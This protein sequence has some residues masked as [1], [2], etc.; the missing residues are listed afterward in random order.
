MRSRLARWLQTR[1]WRRLPRLLKLPRWWPWVLLAVLLP[2]CLVNLAVA[3]VGRCSVFPLSPF[4]LRYKVEALGSYAWHR[5]RC[6]V[7]PDTPLTA[8]AARARRARTS[9][10][11]RPAGGDRARRIGR[12]AAPHLGGRRDGADAA[13]SAH[14]ARHGSERSLQ[15][16]RERGR[17]GPLPARAARHLSPRAPGC[18]R[19]QRRPGRDCRSAM[20]RRTA[21]RRSTSTASCTLSPPSATCAAFPRAPPTAATG[22]GRSVHPPGRQRV[23]HQL[24]IRLHLDRF[25]PCR[26][27]WRPTSAGRRRETASP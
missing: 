25:T 2:I 3:W 21:R 11:L 16:G 23:P 24:G 19:L 9:S 22:R 26:A 27:A 8:P 20:S 1:G 7:V 15:S 17:R 10:A 4:H 6:A 12:T 5:P 14:R 18:R 13:D